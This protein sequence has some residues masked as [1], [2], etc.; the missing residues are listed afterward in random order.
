MCSQDSNLDKIF[1]S[2]EDLTDLE[3]NLP[4]CKTLKQRHTNPKQIPTKARLGVDASQAAAETS[5]S[6]SAASADEADAII[7]L[8]KAKEKLA[9]NTTLQQFHCTT[10]TNYALH[11]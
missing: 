5:S 3:T 11:K 8:K 10:E 1:Q 6:S 2:L 9:T 4:Y 7:V